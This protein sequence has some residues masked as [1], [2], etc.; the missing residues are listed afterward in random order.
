M[1]SGGFQSFSDAFFKWS[2]HLILQEIIEESFESIFFH[3]HHRNSVCHSLVV[4]IR[5][6]KVW[7]I[8][9]GATPAVQ[10]PFLR[11]GHCAAGIFIRHKARQASATDGVAA[12]FPVW[13]AQHHAVPGIVRACAKPGNTRHHYPCRCAESIVHQHPFRS[14]DEA[15]GGCAR[16]VWH[17]CRCCRII[18]CGLSSPRY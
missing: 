12:T 9:R 1:S 14:V 8:F 6:R 2:F 3:D 10:S 16:V 15:T 7:I 18:D 4:S 5:C 17:R 13:N 11:R